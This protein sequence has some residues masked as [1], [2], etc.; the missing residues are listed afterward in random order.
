MIS[1]GFINLC[2]FYRFAEPDCRALKMCRYV[3][4]AAA[5]IAV[6][7]CGVSVVGSSSKVHT[8]AGQKT[9]QVNRQ[10]ETVTLTI[11]AATSLQNV[12]SELQPLFERSH[13]NIR[14][15]YNWGGSGALQRQI[16]QGAPADLFF[17]ASTQQMEALSAQ[18]LI[19]PESKQFLL[20]N[21]LVLITPRGSS[22][23]GLQDLAGQDLADQAQKIAVGEFE[24]VPVGQYTRAMLS[25]ERL[26]RLLTPQLVFFNNVRGVLAAVESGNA[27]AGFV[28]ATDAKLS[29]QVKVVAIAPTR[30]HPPI[31]YPIAILQRSQHPEAAQQYID[32]LNTPEAAQVFQNFGFKAL[33]NTDQSTD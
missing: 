21:R 24:T 18:Q 13:S 17:S 11:S 6:S 19:I 9:E 32:F 27:A 15:F 23:K 31:H 5:L 33:K 29:S 26:L 20:S 4:S 7:G 14:I 28:Y 10:T 30:T 25:S 12:L 22:V 16:E 3:V 2:K 1:A 8:E